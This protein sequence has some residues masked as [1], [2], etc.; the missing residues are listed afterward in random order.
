M[1]INAY[2]RAVS[3]RVVNPIARFLVKVGLTANG[4]TLAG[5]VCTFA[6]IWVVLAVDQRLG[7]VLLGLAAVTDA[8]DGAVARTRG[9]SSN[10]GAFYDSVA[11][12]ISDAALLGVAAWLVR[13]DPVVFT[14]ALVA[15]A[16]AQ[17][18]SYVRAK[19][20][21]LGWSATVGVLERAERVII[22][23]LGFGFDVV[24]LALWVLA[25]GSL[26][27]IG[28]RWRVVARQARAGAR[29]TD[30]TA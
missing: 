21:A 23:I 6:A 26:V 30:R 4:L 24:P 14:V 25:A 15:L 29:T 7:A 22:I 18:T 10:L 8:F 17:L 28:Q 16:G 5:L 9:T 12:R 2:A 3:D 19:A 27:T 20:E 1:A 13:D 11:D